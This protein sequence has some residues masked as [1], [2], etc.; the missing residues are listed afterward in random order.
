MI[1][2]PVPR[3]TSYVADSA[4]TVQGSMT[5]TPATAYP[6]ATNSAAGGTVSASLGTLNPAGAGSFCFRTKI[7]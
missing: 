3:N 1:T 2:D 4:R 6:N 7:N 5:A